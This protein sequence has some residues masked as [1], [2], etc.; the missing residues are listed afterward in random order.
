MTLRA[1]GTRSSREAQAQVNTL[2]ELENERECMLKDALEKRNPRSAD[3]KN[4]T[5]KSAKA[6]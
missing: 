4:E 3:E 2:D 6:I 1:V 5:I